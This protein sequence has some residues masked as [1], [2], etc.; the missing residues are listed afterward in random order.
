MLGKKGFNMTPAKIRK[1]NYSAIIAAIGLAVI[2]LAHF[3]GVVQMVEGKADSADVEAVKDALGEHIGDYRELEAVQKIQ[4]ELIK[5][6]N[7]DVK[8]LLQKVG[9]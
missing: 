6:T 8:T 9:N 7:R 3:A 5:E 4:T 2:L 1:I